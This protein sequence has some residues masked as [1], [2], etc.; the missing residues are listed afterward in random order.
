M[1]LHTRKR[2]ALLLKVAGE[3]RTLHCGQ[4]RVRLLGWKAS[5]GQDCTAQQ[6]Q[7]PLLDTAQG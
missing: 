1:S 4:V 7:S 3:E 6:S 5:Q 2:F